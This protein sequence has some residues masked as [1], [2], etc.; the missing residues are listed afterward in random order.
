MLNKNYLPTISKFKVDIDLKKLRDATDKLTEKF[1]DVKSAN[2]QLCM[3]HEDLVKDVYD[4]F[5]QINLTTTNTVLPFTN[6]IRERLR[7]REE[8]LYNVP[9]DDYVDSY[10]ES[11]IDQFSAP[12][13][14]IRITR[15]AP[16]KTIPFHVDYDVS[17]AVRCICPVY[18]GDNVVNLF[19]RNNKIEAYNLQDGNA[20]FLNVGLPHAV[21]NMSDKPRIAFMFSLDGTDDIQELINT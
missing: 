6:N 20:Y 2:P 13:S 19:K 7:R 17:Y 8:H 9:T 15:L 4:N 11:I 16:K 1:V 14:R 21:V 5:D 10:F 18:G 3:N 12:S